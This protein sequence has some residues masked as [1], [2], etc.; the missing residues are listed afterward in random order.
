M[1]PAP[2]TAATLASEP[3]ESAWLAR[4]RDAPADARPALV[5][6][7]PAAW[8]SALAS[9]L[10]GPE[11]EDALVR[12]QGLPAALLQS[13]WPTRLS[14]LLHEGSYAP[15]LL[16]LDPAG[17]SVLDPAVPPVPA[18]AALRAA[19]AALPLDDALGRVRTHEYLRLCAR[20][21]EGAP[22][23]EVGHD[24]CSPPRACRCCSSSS[25]SRTRSWCSAWA[26]SGATSSTS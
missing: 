18:L 4:L 16:A 3:L 7:A 12:A 19:A 6:E 10:L 11:P 2:P 25:A 23:E 15:R 14:R 17:L 21:V 22:L 24:L 5:A 26:S 1:P 13:P 8:R 9:L 20:E